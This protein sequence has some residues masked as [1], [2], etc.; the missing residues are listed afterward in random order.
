MAALALSVTYSALPMTA[1]PGPGMLA[2]V[3]RANEK[4]AAEPTPFAKPHAEPPAAPPPASVVT[5]PVLADTRR[6]THAAASATYKSSE[7]AA[8]ATPAGRTK[9][10]DVPAP[11][12]TPVRMAGPPPASVETTPV[13]SSSDR[14][15]LL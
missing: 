5:T 2:L 13:A 4:S 7:P 10:A 6:T 1:R 3:P 14:T 15:T 12:A 11:S 8:M 9:R